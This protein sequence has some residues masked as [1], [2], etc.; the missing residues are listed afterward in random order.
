MLTYCPNN[1][2]LNSATLST[3]SVTVAPISYILSFKGTGTITKSGTAT[4]A[5]AGTGASDRVFE[6]FT[7]T[8]GSLTLTVSGTVTEAQLEAVTYQTTPRTY[9]ATTGSAYY[10]PRFDHNPATLAAR[11]LLIEESRTNLCLWSQQFANAAWG[12]KS[13]VT[14]NFATAP[15]GTTTAARINS[16]IASDNVAQLISVT[17]STTYTYFFYARNNG[18]TTSNYRIYD[19]SGSADIV[20]LTSYFSQ[21]NGTTFS[22]ISVTFTTPVACTQ[23]AVYV[24]AGNGPTENV[25][26]W[27]AQLELGAFATSYIPTAAASVTRAADSV[28]M[29]G[30]NF[31]SWYSQSQGTFVVSASTYTTASQ[32]DLVFAGTSGSATPDSLGIYLNSGS[33]LVS[34]A[35]VSN[36]YTG[37]A[38]ASASISVNTLFKVAFG[39]KVDD[40]AACANGG[41][42]GAATPPNALPTVNDLNIGAIGATGLRWNGHIASLT[43]YSTRLPNATLQTLTT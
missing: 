29:T 15:D 25:I 38:T 7:P 40:L 1:L 2:L 26:V 5:L 14:D 8:A 12:S 27:G 3:Q 18:G 21:I 41:S 43:Y 20:P 10:G 4:G 23:V 42:V 34:Y 36:A 33:N 30:T 35:I 19:M 39:Y 37:S 11:G 6:K 9:V 17:A 31:S 22:L 32:R 24:S 16:N 13:Y 28:T